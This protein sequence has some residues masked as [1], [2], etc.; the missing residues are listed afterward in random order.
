[1]C[2]PGVLLQVVE[3]LVK[4]S[5]HSTVQP[6]TI[7]ISTLGNTLVIESERKAKLN[8]D[9]LNLSDF[10]RAYAFYSN[11]QVAIEDREGYTRVKLPHL[12]ENEA[13]A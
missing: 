7:E 1:M 13:A 5:I 11:D 2:V 9:K 6:V 12:F 10:E 4:S 8:S 3:W